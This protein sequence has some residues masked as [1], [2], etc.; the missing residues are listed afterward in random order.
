MCIRDSIKNCAGPCIG[1]QSQEEYLK[2]IAEIK[3]ILKGNTQEIE[4]MLLV[5]VSLLIISLFNTFIEFF[6]S[7]GTCLLYTSRK[8]LVSFPHFD[9]AEREQF[10]FALI[11]SFLVFKGESLSLIHI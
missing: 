10:F 7:R 9:D 4:R 6:V 11:Q 2:N 1:K 3:E 8:A 5:R